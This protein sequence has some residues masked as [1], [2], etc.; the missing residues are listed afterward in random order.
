MTADN[1]LSVLG[2]L[3]AA[4]LEQVDREGPSAVDAFCARHTEHA[5]ALRRR[6]AH[7][8]DLGLVDRGS[9]GPYRLLATLGAG[10]MGV[11]YRARDERLDRIVALKVLPQHLALSERAVQ[12]F[13]R[14]MRAIARLAHDGIV[15]VYDVGED[16]GVRW[17]AMEHIDGRSLAALFNELRARGLAAAELKSSDAPVERAADHRSWVEFAVRVAVDVAHALAHAHEHGIVHRDVKPSNVLLRRDGRALLVDFGLART[18]EDSDVTRTG[19]LTGSPAYMSP[20]QAGGSR[21]D[22]DQRTDIYSLGAILY[23][24]ITLRRAHDGDT[25]QSV[26]ESLRRSDPTPPRAINP[27]VPRDLETICLTTLAKSPTRRYRTARKF[28]ADLQRFLS[29][30]PIHARPAGT[31]ARLVRRARRQPA[32]AAAAALGM[33]VVIGLPLVLAW[34]NAR[35]ASE[36]DV[37][38]QRLDVTRRIN[39]VLMGMLAAPAPHLG[40]PDV[41]VADILDQA[42]A[43]IDGAFAAEPRVELALRSVLGNSY[44]ALGRTKQA[45]QQYEAAEAL[46]DEPTVEPRDVATAL[47][48]L[49]IIRAET[50]AP[51]G[52][53]LLTRACAAWEEVEE[54]PGLDSAQALNNLAAAR[55]KSGDLTGADDALARSIELMRGVPDAPPR[56]LLEAQLNRALL[57]DD[58]DRDPEAVAAYEKMIP[59]AQDVTA[60]GDPLRVTLFS[61]YAQLCRELGR[62]DRSLELHRQALQTARDGMGED[63][64]RTAVIH[65]RLAGALR[66]AEQLEGALRHARQ[67]LTTLRKTEGGGGDRIVFALH[68]VGVALAA[69]DRPAEAM[70]TLTEAT[71][72][73]ARRPKLSWET[74]WPTVA[75][76]ARLYVEAGRRDDA[77]RVLAGFAKRSREAADRV[78]AWRAEH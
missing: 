21:S 45:V 29:L 54:N 44:R 39:D 30:E 2:R 40:G 46:C 78:A 56:L 12:R 77:D 17:F 61:N 22:I 64:P 19:D 74:A 4:C 67:A 14:E 76:L 11:V 9:V 65:L 57:L 53:D 62:L 8:R 34:A 60:A 36:R 72:Q 71:D 55:A 49:G 31:L 15:P 20:E 25:A 63:H 37:A 43:S 32:H 10:G 3:V 38:R 24:A 13:D 27:K 5:A 41:K 69:L 28:A 1:E 50:G 59:F 68:A 7:L 66:Q 48:N 33:V 52:L 18:D 23:E 6:L 70:A 35:I 16:D 26:I 58:S 73:L 47:T 75:E 51:D 42:A